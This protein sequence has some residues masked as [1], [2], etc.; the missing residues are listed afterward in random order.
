M[1]SIGYEDRD[2]PSYR[3]QVESKAKIE[4]LLS[5]PAPLDWN[6]VNGLLQRLTIATSSKSRFSAKDDPMG[7]LLLGRL[8][9][10]NPHAASVEAALRVF[11]DSLSHNPAAFFIACRDASPEVVAQM[12][13]HTLTVSNDDNQRDECPYPWIFSSHVSVDGAKALLE[14]FP[15]GV[16]QKSSFLSSYSP[17]D[18]FLMS[19]DMIEQRAFDVVLWNKFKLLLVAAEC[20]EN[21]GS[22]SKNCGISP[23]HMILKRI[24]SRPGM[25]ALD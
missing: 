7:R 19:A 22:S 24:L 18:Y 11:P 6:V 17:L 10:R 5:D 14:V 20:C 2:D 9:S 21:D 8:L 13:R 25:Y 16:L 3:H 4:D 15:Q 12:M 23:V 1:S